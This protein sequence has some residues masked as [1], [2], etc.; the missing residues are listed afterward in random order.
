[1][2][3]TTESVE[4]SLGSGKSS[5]SQDNVTLEKLEALR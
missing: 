1:M 2:G 3:L 5:V 4:K